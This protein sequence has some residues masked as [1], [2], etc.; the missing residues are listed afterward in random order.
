PPQ[1]PTVTIMLDQSMPVDEGGATRLA[2]VADALKARIQVL[3]PDSGVGLWTFDGVQGRSEISIGPLSEPIN[4]VPRSDALT[5]ALDGQSASGG[6]AVSFTTL[7]LAYTDASAKFRPG[8][9]NSVLVIT[10]GPHTDRSLS[11]SG[12]Q[13]Y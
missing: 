13:D 9:K 4:G 8:Q 6:G 3:P 12:L 11:A 1:S 2:N 10:G 5:A 7:R